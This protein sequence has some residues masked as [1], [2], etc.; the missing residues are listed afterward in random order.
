MI[1]IEAQARE[2]V[3][4]WIYNCLSDLCKERM[5][6]SDREALERVVSTYGDERAKAMEYE[7]EKRADA[8]RLAREEQ[9]RVN[10]VASFERIRV[11][12]HNAAIEEAAKIVTSAAGL[13]VDEDAEIFADYTADIIEEIRALKLPE[14]T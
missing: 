6:L 3:A 8:A 2:V 11:N 9:Y 13:Q 5:K 14:P 1:D 12:A 7:V 4:G 10:T